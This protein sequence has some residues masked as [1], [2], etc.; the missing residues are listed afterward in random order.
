MV[1]TAFAS[2]RAACPAEFILDT[3]TQHFPAVN[4]IATDGATYG[5][6]DV[7]VAGDFSVHYDTYFKVVTTHCGPHLDVAS[8]TPKTYVLSLCGASKPTKFSNGTDLPADVPHFTI[9]VTGVAVPG[10]TP[11][12]FLEM[13]GLRDSIKLVNPAWVHSPCVQHLEETQAIDTEHGEYDTPPGNWEAR[14]ASHPDVQLVFTDSWG[15]GK[16]KTNRDV[17][18]DASSDPGALARAEWIKFVSLFF[19]EEERA[20]LYF[21]RERAAYETIARRAKALSEG[22]ET[23]GSKKTCAWI[24]KFVPWTGPEE[25]HV[26]YTTY[27]QELC[28]GAGMV[29][30]TDPVDLALPNP[31]YKTVFTN[32]TEFHVALKTYDVLV[33]ETYVYAVE[34]ATE[35]IVLANLGVDSAAKRADVFKKGALLLRT[36]RH[37][38]DSITNLTRTNPA[39][40]DWYESAVARPALVLADFANRVWPNK[41][42]APAEGCARYFRDVFAGEMPIINDMHKCET[43]SAAENEQ[44]CLNNP[45]LDTDEG[46]EV[47]AAPKRVGTTIAALVA[48]LAMLAL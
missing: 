31:T 14:A 23:V 25:Y 1:V 20:N 27:K 15:T 32:I 17:V 30:A 18:F 8:C 10:S 44:R 34:S 29:P 47:N 35:A 26:S 43:W 33:D 13:L 40:M 38:T 45:V 37:I 41:M 3:N 36:D 24:Q 2:A 9:P 22:G 39:T 12:T 11:V 6:S 48:A 42:S 16:S 4:R 46:L 28:V 21:S 5:A 7:T 19:N